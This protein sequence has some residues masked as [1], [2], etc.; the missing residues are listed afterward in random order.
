[1]VRH[2]VPHRLIGRLHATTAARQAGVVKNLDARPTRLGLGGESLFEHRDIGRM[3]PDSSR[4]VN[5][6]TLDRLLDQSVHIELT[7]F[8]RLMHDPRSDGDADL[9]GQILQ[10]SQ[11]LE[12]NS[13]GLFELD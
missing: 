9:H 4:C 10:L 11:V 5:C 13:G 7:R 2:F 12:S 8:N 1:M 6:A 3:E